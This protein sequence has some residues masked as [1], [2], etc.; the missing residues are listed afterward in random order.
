MENRDDG[1]RDVD[2]AKRQLMEDAQSIADE[3]VVPMRLNHVLDKVGGELTIQRTG[4]VINAM[5][6]DVMREAF[7]E[8]VDSSHVRKAVG[9]KV[10]KLYKQY[11]QDSL[12][13]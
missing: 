10:A 4:E 13:S 1:Q 9:G 2:P 3:W 12:R 6:E 7:G 5:I 11:L 8:I